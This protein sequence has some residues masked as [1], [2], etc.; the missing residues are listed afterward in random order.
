MHELAYLNVVLLQI[1]FCQTAAEGE[2]GDRQLNASMSV[3]SVKQYLRRLSFLK[4]R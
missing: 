2:T 4:L 1:R 3:S